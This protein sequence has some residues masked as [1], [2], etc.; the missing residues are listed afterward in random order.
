MPSKPTE[1]QLRVLRAAREGRL[2][3][4]HSYTDVRVPYQI[5]CAYVTDTVTAL[6]AWGYLTIHSH[7]PILTRAGRQA[8]AD[9][10]GE[11]A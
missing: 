1:A 9:A 3:T 11:S 10:E 7:W 2:E 6:V 8:L 5:E 4:L